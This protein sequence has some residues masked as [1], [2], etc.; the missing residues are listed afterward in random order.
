MNRS[1]GSVALFELLE[2]L[3]RWW[4]LPL[5]GVCL[6]LGGGLL[7]Y[8]RLPKI[9]EASA[10]VLITPSQIPQNYVRS[11]VPDGAGFSVIAMSEPVLGE[12]L[13]QK[14]AEEI[15]GLPGDTE[16]QK[17]LF[18]RIRAG[19]RSPL[20]QYN[21]RQGTAL[22][23]LTYTD[24]DPDRAARVA[25][26]LADLYIDENARSRTDQ[27][28]TTAG[29]LQKLANGAKAELEAQEKRIAAFRARHVYEIS[30]HLNANLSLLA[31]RQAALDTAER[32]LGKAEDRLQALNNQLFAV[33]SAPAGTVVVPPEPADSPARRLAEAR[34]ELA[35]LKDRYTEEH[36]AVRAKE[37]DIARLEAEASALPPPSPAPAPIL[38]PG[39][40][41]EQVRMDIDATE[42]EIARLRTERERIAGEVNTYRVRIESAPRVEQEL[43]ELTRGYDVLAARYRDLQSKAEEAKGSVEVEEARQGSQFEVIERAAA[44]AAP[45]SPVRWRILVT[46]LVI[47]LLALV[48]PLLVTGL[49][50]PR[51]ASSAG[52]E[53]LDETPVLASISVTPTRETEHARQRFLAINAAAAVSGVVVLVAVALFTLRPGG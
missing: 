39:A 27:A 32:D 33:S 18:G 48:S 53:L 16:G 35:A 9:F 31:T 43:A 47:G 52:L 50:A 49:L 30:D 17:A 12:P 36:P 23:A 28:E 22:F 21:E 19:F 7:T 4:G 8:Q 20:L 10:K 34:R 41:A 25:N 15:Y 42:R 24:T 40:T 44:P 38:A 5:L 37:R 1:P 13:V 11:A 46:G 6:G 51:V 3:A 2:R 29:T 26:F 45:V 14:V